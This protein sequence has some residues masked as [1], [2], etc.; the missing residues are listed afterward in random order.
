[1]RTL[2]A[3]LAAVVVTSAGA[4][5]A[6]VER[7]SFRYVREL[8]ASGGAVRFEPDGRLYAH[9]RPGFADLRIFDAE[10]GQVPWRELPLRPAAS[11]RSVTVLD[12]G[13][14]GRGAVALLD[15]GPG[16]RVRDRI[17]LEI[18]AQG[19]VGRVEV[20]GSD[21]RREFTH[22]STTVVYDVAGV[23]H[24]RS[25]IAAFPPSDFRYLQLRAVGVPRIV[26]ATVS[27]SP[28]RERLLER[29]ITLARRERERTTVV[30]A[31]LH[32]AKVPVDEVSISARS[33]RY[34]RSV[35]IDGS[36]DGRSWTRLAEGRILR[37]DDSA[38][39]AIPLESRYRLLRMSIA[40]GDDEPLVGIAVTARARSRALVAEGGHP[41]P[42][43]LLYGNAAAASPRYEF[44]RLPLDRA[45]V[46]TGR[47]GAERRN[48][49][50]RPAPDTRSFV[51]RHPRVL[52]GALALAAVTLAA[53]GVLALRR[54]T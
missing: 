21:D 43:R 40:N 52:Q 48:P 35:Q 9:T 41:Q 20:S 27:T 8:A 29:K 32:F 38:T 36:N 31:D 45:R 47:L 46:P 14:Q 50:F 13:R 37:S 28:R 25:T 33:E 53:G 16:H 39:G 6:A 22:L 26:G 11:S 1:M 18:P 5:A 19:F 12:S 2:S 23:R 7:S 15:L 3:L 42:Y 17:E 24:A 49:A 51:V 34:L 54:R 30:T 44:A 10:D 4:V